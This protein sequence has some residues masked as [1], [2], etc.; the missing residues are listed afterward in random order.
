MGFMFP[1]SEEDWENYI[2]SIEFFSHPENVELYDRKQELSKRNRVGVKFYCSHTKE[3]V[4]TELERL[5]K[6]FRDM[7]ANT[8]VTY[9][10][11]RKYPVQGDL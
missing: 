7:I 9:L 4:D 8:D 5:S 3:E 1:T 6:E 2:R 11:K 10:Y